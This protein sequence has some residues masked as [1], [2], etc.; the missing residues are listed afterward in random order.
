MNKEDTVRARQMAEQAIA[1]DPGYASAH[2]VLGFTHFFDA[3]FGWSKSPKESLAQASRFAHKALA[4]D[5]ARSGA[6]VVLG[7]IYLRKGQHEKAIAEMEQALALAPTAR[8]YM[9]L[10]RVLSFAGR[11]E[12]AIR[13]LEKVLRL[14]PFAGTVELYSLG[15]AYLMAGRYD[16]AIAAFKRSIEM[17][18]RSLIAH[19]YLASAYNLSG[20]EQEARTEAEEVLK[21]SPK[22]CIR[23]GKGSYK[24]PTDAE[25]VNN[26]LRKAGVPDC[27]PRGSAK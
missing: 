15:H 12:E 26:A 6:Y 21:I 3:V 22:Y 8:Q 1:L 7:Y 10:G 24:N 16:E 19:L 5:D 9:H 13:L 23:G 2:V 20:R 17:A 18:P 25:L 4:L 14:D 11:Q 27:P